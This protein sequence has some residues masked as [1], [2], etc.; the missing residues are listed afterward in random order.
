MNIDW[1]TVAAQALNFVVLIWLLKRF[2]Y[3]PILNAIEARE[4][5]IAQQLADAKAT[6]IKAE[7]EQA[8]FKEKI[9]SFDKHKAQL[10]NDAKHE[11]DRQHMELLQDAQDEAEAL[12]AKAKATLKSEMD[13]MNADILKQTTAQIFALSAKILTDLADITLQDR[14]IAVF[15]KNVKALNK[16]DQQTALSAK[17]AVIASAFTLSQPQQKMLKSDLKIDTITFKVV[18]HLVSGIELSVKGHKLAW[19]INDYLTTLETDMEQ[20]IAHAA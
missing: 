14:M 12:R 5:H 4:K 13:D 17:D 19:S 7:Q 8:S 15:I 2:L 10:L 11:A 9:E 16:K 3:K 20:D 1:F 6:Q 18:P